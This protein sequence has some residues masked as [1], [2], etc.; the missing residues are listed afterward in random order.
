[1]E[2]NVFALIYI[3]IMGQMI[4]VL[5]VQILN[6]QHVK[7][8]QTLAVNNSII[9]IEYQ[10]YLL[11]IYIILQFILIATC[12]EPTNMDLTECECKDSL[13]LYFDGTSGVC[14]NCDEHCLVYLHY[15]YN[16]TIYFFNVSLNRLA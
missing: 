15:S 5:R 3:M 9:S 4:Y 2:L 7:T 16:L 8:L 11:L 14:E 13:S 10:L 1:M 12:K 6:V